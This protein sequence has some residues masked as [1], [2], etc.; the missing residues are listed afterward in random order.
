MTGQTNERFAA[1]VDVG[2]LLQPEKRFYSR[3]IGDNYTSNIDARTHNAALHRCV[4]CDRDLACSRERDLPM[5][6]VSMYCVPFT[7]VHECATLTAVVID[8]FY[9]SGTV[10]IAKV[11]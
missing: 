1:V 8:A 6:V 2:P 10:Q 4:Y 5:C 9:C 11:K 3:K 7:C